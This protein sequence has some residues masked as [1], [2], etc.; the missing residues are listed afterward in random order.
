M[1]S[2]E[3]LAKKVTPAPAAAAPEAPKGAPLD[4]S[5]RLSGRRTTGEAEAMAIEISNAPIP[6][7]REQSDELKGRLLS[8]LGM[9]AMLAPIP[10]AESIPFS[11]DMEPRNVRDRI[12]QGPRVYRSPQERISKEDLPAPVTAVITKGEPRMIHP[13]L[14]KPGRSIKGDSPPYRPI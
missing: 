12:A 7:S 11:P 4:V 3:E 10:N 13:D 6:L 5:E 1:S 2:F 8:A 9:F 14:N